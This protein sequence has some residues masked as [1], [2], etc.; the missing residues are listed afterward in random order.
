MVSCSSITYT[1][2]QNLNDLLY[3]YVVIADKY[4]DSSS[5]FKVYRKYLYAS[6]TFD[7]I[8]YKCILCC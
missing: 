4:T 7:D 8:F 1:I 3:S 2:S 6:K 5:T